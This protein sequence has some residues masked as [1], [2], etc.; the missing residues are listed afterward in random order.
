MAEHSITKT[1]AAKP[2]PK[3]IFY[4]SVFSSRANPGD[5]KRASAPLEV[6]NNKI[7]YDHGGILKGGG[8]WE[9]RFTGKSGNSKTSKK[10]MFFQGF[11]GNY[12]VPHDFGGP[13]PSSLFVSWKLSSRAEEKRKMLEKQNMF[14]S[15]KGSKEWRSKCWNT[16]KTI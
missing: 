8:K 4:R 14:V 12:S 11:S 1:R 9:G 7:I 2:M 6:D 10:T 16:V 3:Q 5:W 13:N 15:I